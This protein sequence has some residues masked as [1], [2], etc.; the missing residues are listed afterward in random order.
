MEFEKWNIKELSE[1]LNIGLD[2]FVF[3]DDNPRERGAVK[4]A[5]PD[6]CVPEFPEDTTKLEKFIIEI[7]KDYFLPLKLTNE[8]KK[9]STL[10]KQNFD[11]E[12]AKKTSASFEDFL[13]SLETRIN[14]THARLEDVDRIAQL[15]QKTNQFNITTKRY[16]KQDILEFIKSKEHEVF[17]GNVIDRYGDNGKVIVVILKK[18]KEESKIVIDTFLMSCRVMG[19][20]IEDSVFDFIENYALKFDFKELVSNYNKTSKNQP[21]VNFFDRMGYET[22]KE[23]EKGNKVYT[24]DLRKKINRKLYYEVNNSWC[25]WM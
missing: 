20:F 2:S 1:E 11:R 12:K 9:K 19:R 15:T 21:V 4:Q 16:T 5:L 3:I 8:D 24:Y 17:I 23:D 10:Y 22:I 18:D 14:L 25:A 13:F 7:Y 6:V